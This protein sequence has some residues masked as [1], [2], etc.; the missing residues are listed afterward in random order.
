MPDCVL[1]CIE[2]RDTETSL[3]CHPAFKL[4]PG[5]DR[6]FI[7]A[8]LATIKGESGTQQSRAFLEL[9]RK[10]KFCVIFSGSGLTYALDG[11]FDMFIEMVHQLNR[12]ARIAVIPMVS[13]SNTRGFNHSL[14]QRTGYV[15]KVSFAG[16]VSNGEEASF[17]E[18]VRGRS[19]DCILIV[20]SDPFL[21]LPQSLMISLEGIP[22]IC[23]NPVVTPTT[24][25]ARVVLG[26]ATSGIEADGKVR[27]MDGEEVELLK[28]KESEHPTDEEVL[29]RL[30]ARIRK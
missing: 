30:L 18:Q 1:S 8:V 24:N 19:A 3:I 29:G 16:G 7:Q 14:Y 28:I 6:D 21:D 2:V 23:L 13:H 15:N 10:A 12:W 5:E 4:K 9:T 26:T 22:V 11:D 25:R 17:L 20:G 27:R